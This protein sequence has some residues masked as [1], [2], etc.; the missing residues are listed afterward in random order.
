M[1]AQGATLSDGRAPRGAQFLTGRAPALDRP[2]RR[3]CANRCSASPAMTDAATSPGWNGWGNG[4]T[5]TRFAPDGGLTAADLPR[6]KLKWAF[7]YSGVNA[8]RAQPTIAGGRLFVASENGEAHALDPKT[9]CTHW[10]FQAQAGIRTGPRRRA[11]QDGVR[12]GPGGLLRR[13]QGQRLRGGRA[14]RPRAVGAQGRRAS[15]GVA[16]R[17]AGRP[18]W[19]G[20]RAGAGA[21]RGRPGRHRQVPVLHVPRQPGRAR[22]EHRRASLWK[23]YMVDAAAAARQERRRAS[24]CRARP[25]AASGRR[26]PSMP[27][28]NVVY[29]ATGNGYADPPQPMTDAVVAMDL[30]TGAVKWVRQTTPNDSW[31]LGC[32]PKNADNPACPA[33]LG[34]DYDFSASPSLATVNGRDLLVLPQKSGMALCA[35][36]GQERRD[37]VAAAHRPGQR[38]GRPVGRRGGRAAGLLRRLRSPDADAGRHAGAQPRHRRAGVERRAA[39]AAL[40]RG[41]HVPRVAGRRGQRDSRARCSRA[42]ST[43]GCA[44][45]PPPTAPSSGP[46][47]AIASSRPSTA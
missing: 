30:Q 27:S 35:R 41:A 19:P 47:T 20:L 38:P 39:E 17:R 33:T 2:P 15:R 46:S 8:A 40:R 3:R 9:G 26:R 29:V 1:Q 44:P 10:T 42:R 7:G 6:L 23:T 34:P 31:T 18:R 32:P 4:A 36:S 11:L 37:G 28:A 22:R 43:A 14:H 45:T 25:A 12:L 21:E 16:H 13:R 24:R 5:N